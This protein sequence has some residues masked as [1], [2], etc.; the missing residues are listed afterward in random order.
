MDYIE[1]KTQVLPVSK[2]SNEIII[3][4]LAERGFE[5]FIEDDNGLSAYINAPAF[6]NEIIKKINELTLPE[7]TK[8]S[9]QIER[10]KGQNWNAQWESSFE[11][12]NVNDRCLVRASFHE[13]MPQF[14]FEIII[15]PKMAFG[16][17]HHQTTYL[18][19][20]AIL[21]AEFGNK[22]VLDM[23]CG[24]GVLAILAEMK[25][26]KSIMAIDIDEWAYKNI[27]E[28]IQI[29]GSSK[30]E[31]LCGDVQLIKDKKFDIVLANINLNI[32]ISDIK[33]YEQS[34]H[35]NGTLLI[36]G[37]LKPDIETIMKV[38]FEAGLIHTY[39]ATRDEWVMI[40][41]RKLVN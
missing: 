31:P 5:S 28:N 8:I 9:Y 11:P 39:T 25:G 21:N 22:V 19:I 32:L 2:E 36:S 20:E 29:N 13:N 7:N 6:S 14:E 3:A 40:S 35:P 41:F 37:I 1:I 16:T 12:I 30:I 24:T 18:M 10:I 17:G 38:A 27:L 15:D 4:Q 26:A 34:L 33:H 23:G